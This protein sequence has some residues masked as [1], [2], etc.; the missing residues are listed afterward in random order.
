MDK[1]SLYTLEPVESQ[2]KSIPLYLRNIP[3]SAT[4][5]SSRPSDILLKGPK[6]II[7]N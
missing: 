3:G 6:N 1:I 4:S 7:L 2:A 5:H